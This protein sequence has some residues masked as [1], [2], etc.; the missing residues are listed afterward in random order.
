LFSQRSIR[1]RFLIQLIVASAA[2]LSI[3]SSI[4]FFYIQSSIYDEKRQELIALAQ[5]ISTYQSLHDAKRN[6]ADVLLGVSIELVERQTNQNMLF[7]EHT[8]NNRT[9]LRLFYPFNFQENTYIQITKDISPTKKLFKKI[10]NSIFLINAIGFILIVIYAI[11]L[12]TM[13]TAPIR[14]LSRKLSN[15]NEHLIRPIRVDELPEE[16]EPLGETINRLISR[17]QNFIKYQKELFIGTAHELKTPLAVIK[18]KNQVTL[19]KKRNPQEYIDAITATNVTIDEMDQLVSAILNVG[20]QE[21]AQLESPEDVD[22]IAFIKS[23]ADDFRLLAEHEGKILKISLSPG[24]YAATLQLQLLNQI[25]QNFLQNALK[26]TPE[27]GSVLLQSY[28][29][30]TGLMIEVIDEG[31]GI[32]SSIDL[33]APFKRQGSKS[34]AGLGLFLA[35]SAADAMGADI[36]I[37]NREDAQHGTIA[38][39]HLYSKLCCNLYAK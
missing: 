32:D 12:S 3:F 21:G 4:L 20:R 5:N 22:V 30:D 34:G 24:A 18:L 15:M 19:L 7:V 23:K 9:Y 31:C 2:L 1:N 10:L 16:F 6:D 38:S 17:I 37:K 35:K 13:L 28:L 36:S 29:D 39:L 11:T 25:I 14:T 26:F 8:K 33:F 27:G